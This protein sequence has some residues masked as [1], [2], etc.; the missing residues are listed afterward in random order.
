M[1][2]VKIGKKKALPASGEKVW[3]RSYTLTFVLLSMIMYS[4]NIIYHKSF[5][6]SG[7]NLAGDGLVQHYTALA[8][9]GE[10]LRTIGRNFFK[11]F[12]FSIPE[13]DL[14]IGL[15]GSIITTLGYEMLGDPFNLLAAFVPMQYTEY[16]YVFL[17]ILRLYLAGI[18]FCHLY[19]CA[20]D[21]T[22]FFSKSAYL[23]AAGVIGSG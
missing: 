13:F 18:A 19:G 8:Y 23:S 2:R 14:S 11:T 22:S 3:M 10:Y 1:H 7:V 15:G 6:Y 4:L 20:T 17:V 21:T 16:L 12:T 5:V 9:Y